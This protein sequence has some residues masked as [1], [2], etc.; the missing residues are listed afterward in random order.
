MLFGQDTGSGENC[1]FRKDP[2]AYLERVSRERWAS[3]QQT[4]KLAAARFSASDGPRTVAP[5][6]IPRRSFID[7]EIFD[8][9]AK[10]GIPSA[11]LT[12]DEEFVRR[13]YLDLTGRLPAAADVRKFV[14]DSAGDKRSAL[15]DRLLYS[16]AFAERWT[17]W[18]GD[19]LGVT[20]QTSNVNLQVQ[21]RNALH[22]WLRI[23][24]GREKSLKDIAYEAVTAAGNGFEV[25]A[26]NYVVLGRQSMGPNQDWYDLMLYQTA[27]KFLG[28]SHYDCVLCHDGRG[29]L[30]EISLWGRRVT[31]LQAE[32]MAAFFS[33]VSLTQ[34][35]PAASPLT[36]SWVVGDNRTGNYV[37]GTTFGN[38]P[39]RLVVGTL[40]SLDPEYRD[41]TKAASVNWRTDFAENLVRDPLMAVNFA[42]RI[43]KAMFNYGLVEP[44]NTLDP[45]RLDPAAPPAAPWQ[46]QPSHPKLLQLLAQDLATRDFNLREFVRLI[47]ESSAYQLSTRYDSGWNVSQV[48]LFARHYPRRLEGEEIHDAVAKSTGVVTNYVPA[49]WADSV[50]WAVQFPDPSEPRANGTTLTFLAPF[51]RGNRDTMTRNQAGSILQQLTLMNNTFVTAKT[52]MNAS[53]TLKAAAAI[54]DNNVAVEELYLTF[55]A[56]RPSAYEKAQAAGHFAKAPNRN[57]AIEDIAWALIN[58]AEFLFS[59]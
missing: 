25:G 5:G 28:V 26:A 59:Y 54:T 8:R 41:G 7:A 44:V 2:D 35:F 6:D 22:D 52:K 57:T 48:P 49:G 50:Q 36:G 11:R 58:K 30:D 55:L 53:P 20:Q 47:A 33:R 31:R 3:Y 17:M 24:M 46:L 4:G 19:I 9:L 10:D 34:P 21:G 51:L 39:N 29:H 40:R 12:T 42:N 18:L 1:T 14:D 15:I 13:I 16:P 27:E 23:S 45:A 43:W 38:R 56:R 32:S 37:L